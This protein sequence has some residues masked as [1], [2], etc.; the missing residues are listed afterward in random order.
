MALLLSLEAS[1]QVCSVALHKE[2][3]LLASRETQTPRSAAAQLAVMIQEVMAQSKCKPVDL[4]GVIVASGPGSYTGLRIAVATAKGLCYALNVPLISVNTLQLLASQGKDVVTIDSK[5]F[6]QTKVLFCPMLDARRMEVYC[7]LLDF[8]LQEIEPTQ[9]RIIDERSF[10]EHLEQKAIYFLGEGAQK[11]IGIFNHPNALFFPHLT[12]D[13][14]R[15][16]EVGYS[17]WQHSLFEDVATFEPF[18]L[19]DFLI[20][21]PNLV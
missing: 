5:R 19:K 4:N 20:K 2:G 7:M 1:T 13:A 6:D 8:N 12:P 21:K 11:C 18:Y 16:G 17:K 9:A 14:K 15:L 3:M 10:A